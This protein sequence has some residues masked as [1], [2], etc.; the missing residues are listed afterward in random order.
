VKGSSLQLIP[1]TVI[2][3]DPQGL[4]DTI[5]LSCSEKDGVKNGQAVI[6]N[7][8]LVARVVLAGSVSSTAQLITHPKASVDAKLSKSGVEGV[9]RGSFGSGLIF[10]A[11]TPN[12]TVDPRDMVI[13]AGI[14]GII[15]KNIAI[16]EV[17]D[18]ISKD[19]ELSKRATL[20]S[21]IKFGS[22]DL[23]FVG[24]Q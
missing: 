1:C 6:S 22:V 2:S 11:V 16:G 10:E 13:T 9:V 4:T 23:V 8:F 7:G 18:I 21:P 24:A 20:A 12:A 5:I 19:N 3:R 14:D 17:R 15:P